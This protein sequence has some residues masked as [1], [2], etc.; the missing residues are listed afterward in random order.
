MKKFTKI[1]ALAM[2]L[3]LIL[4]LVACGAPKTEALPPEIALI[5]D[6]GN[7]DDK[8]FNEG[9]WN[10]VKAYG[11][12]NKIGY[13]YYR[14]TEDSN[15]A[16]VETM[17][18]AIAK[19]A[20]TV[21][22]PGFLFENSIYEL[23]TTY[24]D[25]NFL[26]LDGEPHD[27]SDPAVYKSEANTHC[28]L[29]K[30]EQAGY[31][32]G[33]AAVMDGYRS[34]GFLGGMAVPAVVRYGYG[35]VQ[36]AEAASAKLGLA[37]GDVTMKY[38]YAGAFS[39]NDDIKTRMDGWYTEGTEVIFS[40]GGGIYLSACAAADAAGKKV[41]GVDVDQASQS[42][43]IITS[44]MK[45]LTKSVELALTS[46]YASDLKWDADHAGKTAV[47]GAAEDCVGLPTA[48]ESWKLENFK[49]ADY[50]ALF[51]TLKDGSVVVDN[52]YDPAV[53]PVTTLVTVDYQG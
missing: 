29:Y 38:W 1:I 34:L 10:G 37:A 48:K 44:A 46:L 18:D 45:E 36:G 7:I 22:C 6:V 50:E 12:A 52:S 2:A 47:L 8:S 53:T 5:T 4:P 30:E 21:V 26:L 24:P 28:I 49:V 11:E 13:A 42:P 20:K 40:C 17:K 39:P 51:A 35:F 9:S 23:Q 32:A 43:T 25:V 31:L 41:I 15:E 27:T 14:P 3:A 19:G 16:R 33:Y